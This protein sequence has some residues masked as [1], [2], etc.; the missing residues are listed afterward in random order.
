MIKIKWTTKEDLDDVL[1][2]L[3][4]LGREEDLVKIKDKS[5]KKG[6]THKDE[7]TLADEIDGKIKD[8]KSK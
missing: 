8:K 1:T 6:F 4:A 5:A 7:T 3:I 2:C